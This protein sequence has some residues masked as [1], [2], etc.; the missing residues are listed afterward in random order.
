MS[1]EIIINS[2]AIL[3]KNQSEFAKT[4]GI[5]ASGLFSS[6]G[7]LVSLREDVGRHNA[8]DKVIGH[9]LINN[10]SSQM[11]NLLLVLDV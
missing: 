5:H 1:K 7:N 6:N 4:G 10:T 9:S 2:P 8:L 11:T 3:R